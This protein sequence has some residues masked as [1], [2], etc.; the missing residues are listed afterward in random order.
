MKT[1]KKS[2]AKEAFLQDATYTLYFFG[3][4]VDYEHRVVRAGAGRLCTAARAVV[5]KLSVSFD[6]QA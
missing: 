4:E 1:K 6:L 5:G 2:A 3:K